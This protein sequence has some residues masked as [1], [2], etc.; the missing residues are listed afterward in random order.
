LKTYIFSDS[1]IPFSNKAFL[2]FL[3]R[4]QEVDVH[5]VI[6]NGDVYDLLRVPFEEII[7]REPGKTL[8]QELMKLAKRKKVILVLGNHDATL[9]NYQG[10]LPFEIVDSLDLNGYHIE[11]GHRFDLE[12]QWL[13]W[14]LLIRLL[15][16]LW[17]TPSRLKEAGKAKKYQWLVGTIHGKALA[18]LARSGYRGLIMG[19]THFGLLATLED[20]RVLADSGDFLDSASFLELEGGKVRLRRLKGRK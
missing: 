19:H 11:H 18:W 9:K 2:T 12:C 4:A 15:Q 3:R 14:R 8:H 16:G 1:H 17:Q 5:I 20:G 13:P 10:D 6:G 7:S